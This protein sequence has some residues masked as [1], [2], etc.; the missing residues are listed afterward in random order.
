MCVCVCARLVKQWAQ[1][2]CFA[3]NQRIKH[4][5][6]TNTN[7]AATVEILVRCG[8]V[9]CSFHCSVNFTLLSM[10]FWALINPMHLT[11]CHFFQFLVDIR[12]YK[13]LYIFSKMNPS[14]AICSICR[15]EIFDGQELNTTL[16]GHVFHRACIR[17]SIHK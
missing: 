1:A 5:H 16:C 9:W 11:S 13:V 10:S 17:F 7:K 4:T 15:C 3:P 6:S 12:V 2:Q 14:D 8:A